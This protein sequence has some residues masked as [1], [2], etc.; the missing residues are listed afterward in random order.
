VLPEPRPFRA[1]AGLPRLDMIAKWRSAS[2][3]K[4]FDSQDFSYVNVQIGNVKDLAGGWLKLT[5][6]VWLYPG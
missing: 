6:S 5:I 3:F 1:L 2:L 4:C